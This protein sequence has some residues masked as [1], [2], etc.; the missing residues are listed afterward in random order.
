MKNIEKQIDKLK[1]ASKIIDI[2]K[3][4][5]DNG[6]DKSF[7]DN[8]R[9]SDIF[10]FEKFKFCFYSEAQKQ[11]HN[12]IPVTINSSGITDIIEKYNYIMK[13][14]DNNNNNNFNKLIEIFISILSD[15]KI[16]IL[17]SHLNTQILKNIDEQ[18]D[19]KI[20]KLNLI[21]ISKLEAKR[22]VLII[23]TPIII[24]PFIKSCV[25]HLIQKHFDKNIVLSTI[26]IT[27]I[28]IVVM[29]LMYSNIQ[30]KIYKHM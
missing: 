3:I 28:G 11:N 15:Y 2:F 24:A 12:S 4:I 16:K 5:V 14:K 23:T 17:T 25:D 26:G 19:K 8:N 22:S 6:S 10:N 30:Q 20:K 9:V 1:L 29:G 27:L 18:L 7:I 13:I 21:E